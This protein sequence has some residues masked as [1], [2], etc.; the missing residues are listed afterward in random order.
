M[1]VEKYQYD[2]KFEK[3]LKDYEEKKSYIVDK[4]SR[5]SIKDI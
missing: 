4:S 3:L 2:V 1:L 5:K